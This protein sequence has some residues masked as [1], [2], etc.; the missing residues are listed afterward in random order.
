MWRCD[1]KWSPPTLQRLYVNP[2]LVIK[3][4]PP[5]PS[6]SQT[7]S[8]QTQQLKTTIWPTTGNRWVVC[9]RVFWERGPWRKWGFSIIEHLNIVNNHASVTHQNAVSTGNIRDYHRKDKTWIQWGFNVDYLQE[10]ICFFRSF[11]HTSGLSQSGFGLSGVLPPILIS[12][13]LYTYTTLS[14]C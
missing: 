10:G 5:S 3:T 6:C 2:R 7:E 14:I 1:Q 11:L 13:Q 12:E 8:S 4:P 9:G